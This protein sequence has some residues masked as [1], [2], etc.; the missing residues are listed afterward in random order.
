MVKGL[1]VLWAQTVLRE[2]LPREAEPRL[3][4]RQHLALVAVVQKA[5]VWVSGLVKLDLKTQSAEIVWQN[6]LAH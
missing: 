5:A 4:L 1:E 2:Q 3:G 6:A